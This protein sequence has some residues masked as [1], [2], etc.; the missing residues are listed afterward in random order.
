MRRSP[1]PTVAL[2]AAALLSPSAAAADPAT[3][4]ALENRLSDALAAYDSRTVDGLWDDAFVFVTPGGR[5]AHKA[6]RMKGLSRPAADVSGPVLTSHNDAVDVQY[7]DAHLAVVTVRSSWKLGEAI[8]G[9][10]YMATHVW[11]RRGDR[12][13]LLSAQ[14]AQ[15]A[16]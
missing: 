10:P 9:D 16:P 5:I 13:R 14:V 15:I 11:I 3:F 12:W 7:E 4:V 6:Q 2:I 8:Q 1:I